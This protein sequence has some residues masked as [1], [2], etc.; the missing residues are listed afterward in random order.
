MKQVVG[1]NL[2]LRIGLI[3][4]L[5]LSLLSNATPGQL[6]AVDHTDSRLVQVNA[7]LAESANEKIN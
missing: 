7:D 2:V 1:R 4:C 5:G 6:K 3:R